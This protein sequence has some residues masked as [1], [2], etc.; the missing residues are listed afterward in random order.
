MDEITGDPLMDFLSHIPVTNTIDVPRGQLLMHAGCSGPLWRVTHGV[1]K[2]V[3]HG[4]DGDT[5]VQLAQTGDLIGVEALCASPYAFTAIALVKAQV[6]SVGMPSSL[7]AYDTMSVGF[8]QQQRQTCDMLRLRTGPI[9]QRLSCLLQILGKQ[10]DGRIL[11]VQRKELPTLKEMARVVDA[12]FETVCRE[13]NS[14]M[15]EHKRVQ[16]RVTAKW[17]R[18]CPIAV[19]V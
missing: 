1:F 16:K 5:L 15:P 19:S 14:L 17:I 9:A 3:R 18:P 13:L 2:L 4:Q 7:D 10:A 11:R 12:S 8:V 6:Q